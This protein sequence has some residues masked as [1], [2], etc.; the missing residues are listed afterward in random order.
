MFCL[1]C[2]APLGSEARFCPK[3]GTARPQVFCSKCGEKLNASAKFCLKCGAK[4]VVAET[5]PKSAEPHDAIPPIAPN[6]KLLLWFAVLALVGF[7]VL[8]MTLNLVKLN[9][10]V[11]HKIACV[12]GGAC[13]IAAFAV[14]G[15]H[16]G[17]R[18]I[19]LPG[20]IGT[21][22]TFGSMVFRMFREC[23]E[24]G[25]LEVNA[26]F[27]CVGVLFIFGAL[28]KMWHIVPRWAFW[29]SIL[30]W[31][32]LLWLNVSEIMLLNQR[33]TLVDFT[34]AVGDFYNMVRWSWLASPVILSLPLFV[35][36]LLRRGKLDLA[37]HSASLAPSTDLCLN[38]PSRLVSFNGRICRSAYWGMFGLGI[39]VVVL[40]GICF[41]IGDGRSFLVELSW[42]CVG[43]A[44]ILAFQWLVALPCVIRR[45]HDFG[46]PGWVVVLLVALGSIPLIG[47][48]LGLIV[49]IVLGCIDSAQGKNC[50]GPDPKA[51]LRAF[52][53][54]TI[55]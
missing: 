36:I 10:F 22:L 16:K 13:R 3:C 50:Y 24:V 21:T 25:C 28:L 30:G 18:G 43:W 19:A 41:A 12:F 9:S 49:L 6:P 20:I 40:S 1:K 47:W 42:D 48:L 33:P 15:F 55:I 46:L 14:L 39:V 44:I 5:E 34:N 26:W 38:D 27:V 29:P 54:R 35:S 7:S 11:V 51:A 52:I 17:M 37:A 8:P 45:G 31:L 2:H 32:V 53:P 23:S 4:V